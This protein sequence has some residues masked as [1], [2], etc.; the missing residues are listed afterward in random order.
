[1]IM[2]RNITLNASNRVSFRSKLV[3]TRK[4]SIVYFWARWCA[5]CRESIEFI[6]Q[7][8][9]GTSQK[10]C[11]YNV[12]I[13]NSSLITNE[14]NIKCV[15]TLLFLHKYKVMKRVSGVI[16]NERLSEIIKIFSI[17]KNH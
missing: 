12:N 1:M 9:L 8:Y 5:A 14:Y 13:G 7:I 17:K 3:R 11:I 2:L 15:P 4:F 10:F 6:R 16:S